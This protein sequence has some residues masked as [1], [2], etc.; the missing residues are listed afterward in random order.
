[1]QITTDHANRHSEEDFSKQFL[2]LVDSGAGVIHVRASEV[3][4][5]TLCIRKTILL[6][7]G[8][9]NEW[10][11]VNG[12]REFTIDNY[13]DEGVKGDD[14]SDLGSAFSAPLAKLREGS[15]GDD[16]IYYVYQNPHPFMENNPHMHQL[17]LMYNEFL[18]SCRVCVVLVTP[19]IPL[20]DSAANSSILA[21]HFNTPGL[22]ELRASLDSIVSDSGE[23]FPGGLKIDTKEAD[24]I[25]YSGAGMSALQFETYVSLGAVRAA[26]DGM[27]T[28]TADA[29][30][31]EVQRGKTDI[32]NSSD[33]LELYPSTNIDDVGGMENLKEWLRRRANCYSDEAAAFGIEAPKGLVLVG[34]PG[35]GK[36]LVAKAASSVLGVPLVRMDFGKVFSSFV[37]SSEQRIRQA[38]R[39]VEAMSPLVLFVDEIDKGLGGIGQGGGGD[40]GVS[41]RVL[42][43]F[44]TWLQDCTFPVFTLVTANNID[45][46]PPELLRRGRFDAIF[47]T[48]LP[49]PRERQ[50]VLAIHLRKRDRDIDDFSE[51]EVKAMLDA[52]DRYVPAELESAVKDGLIN[53]FSEGEDFTAQHVVNA[54]TEMVPLSKAFEAQINKMNEW[55][56]SNAT[57]VSANDDERAARAVA[58]KNRS[59]V[60]TRRRPAK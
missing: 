20:P 29:V 39:Q 30:Q 19:D 21:V 49:T 11:I 14:N 53:A 2:M 58:A 60:S 45:Q 40:S 48:S 47:S 50:E 56:K 26:K 33:I 57:P 55:A 23:D 8:K 41:M 34:P 16:T 32:V 4:R 18:P 35:S 22:I 24:R 1:M 10:D 6:D 9:C 13:V 15:A 7:K 42:G 51:E 27:E 5:A 44:L 3:L 25:C 31:S 28:L 52:S 17:L 43:S 38:L 54:L 37:G 46:L 59:R 12:T 36:S